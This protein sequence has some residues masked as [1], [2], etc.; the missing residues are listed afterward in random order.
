MPA[1]ILVLL[2][3]VAFTGGWFL[4]LFFLTRSLV[5][6]DRLI[7]AITTVICFI[8]VTFAGVILAL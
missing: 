3:F 4:A 8:V 2:F 6:Y 1:S 5:I 7:I